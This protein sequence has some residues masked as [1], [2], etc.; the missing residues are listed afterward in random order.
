MAFSLDKIVFSP[1]LDPI[2]VTHTVGFGSSIN[3]VYS[4]QNVDVNEVKVNI[5]SPTGVKVEPSFIQLAPQQRETVVITADRTFFDTLPKGTNNFNIKF[6][7]Q[8]QG[9]PIDPTSD[10]LIYE[11]QL[12]STPSLTLKVGQTAAI[13]AQVLEKNLTKQTQNVVMNRII[14]YQSSN[15]GIVSVGQLNGIADGV[16]P[17]NAQITVSSQGA[18]QA[19]VL[20][21][22]YADPPAPRWWEKVVV[23]TTSGQKFFAGPFTTPIQPYPT[24]ETRNGILYDV[25]YVEISEDRMNT[26]TYYYDWVDVTNNVQQLTDTEKLAKGYIASSTK[27]AAPAPQTVDGNIVRVVTNSKYEERIVAVPVPSQSMIPSPTPSPT[28]PTIPP[29]PTPSASKTVQVCTTIGKVNS[30][31][32]VNACQSLVCRDQQDPNGGCVSVCVVEGAPCPP[33]S[34]P[35]TPSNSPVITTP[36]CYETGVWWDRADSTIYPPPMVS[37]VGCDGVQVDEVIPFDNSATMP[38]MICNR[39]ILSTFRVLVGTTMAS[40]NCKAAPPPPPP[41]PPTPSRTPLP[42]QTITFGVFDGIPGSGIIS[43]PYDSG[44]TFSITI[45]WGQGVPV[46]CWANSGYEF[47]YA[48][49]FDRVGNEVGRI[50]QGNFMIYADGVVDEVRV[51]FRLAIGIPPTG[52][53]GTGGGGTGPLKT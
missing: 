28:K 2:S 33:Q 10:V 43:T 9:D 40:A 31:T 34:P 50:V 15:T 48:A 37:Y 44:R 12:T 42:D 23:N 26:T 51:Y 32:P 1:V 35:P 49:K 30:S 45:P 16:S 24:R 19:I 13:T 27:P 17:G 11:L 46:D 52:G 6:E 8:G 47:D 36:T 21:G 20:V 53:G 3:R 39:Y 22:V 4:I 29:T 5:Q 41:P 38:Y 7:F 14:T 18:G 25:Y